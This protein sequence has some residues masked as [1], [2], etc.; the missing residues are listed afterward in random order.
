MPSG[1]GGHP[2][3]IVMLTADAY[4]VLP[5]IARLSAEGA[6]YHYLSGYTAKVAGT[7][8][9]VTEPSATFSTCFGAPFL[10]LNPERLREAARRAH[11]E[12][13]L[14]RVAGQ[15]RL[16]RRAARRRQPHEDCLHARD[17]SRRAVGCSST[18]SAYQR[19]PIFNI[20][21]P[22]S[23]PDVP[24]AVLDPR[25][26]WADKAAYDAQAAKLARMFVENFKT[27][28]AD[29]EPTVVAAGPTDLDRLSRVS[30][31][32]YEAVIGLE[33]HAQLLT[34][35]KI[36]CGCP[37]AF[38]AP[39]NAHACPVCVGLPGALPV[40][41]RK[42]VD[43][44]VTAAL[45]LGCDVQER[46]VFA[47]KNYFYPDLPKGYQISQYEQPLALGGGVTLPASLA[48]EVREADAHPH[49]RGRGQVAARRLSPIPIARPT[50]ITTAAACR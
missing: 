47:R 7:E 6:M 25:G 11:R 4:G 33:I 16:D 24:A 46:S 30:S 36:F 19:H 35:T 14:A 45:A 8:K 13:R 43:L 10:P 15:H 27:N 28:F 34:A 40:L 20:D 2:K 38:G 17:D 44:A 29:A 48:I 42:A 32:T 21:V 3:N 9:G 22:T 23:C 49:G 39:P 18:T 1:I 12:A 41:N 31:D 37:T 26:T 5:P 50:S